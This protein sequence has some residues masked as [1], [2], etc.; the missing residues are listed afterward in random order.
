[1]RLR[2][3]DLYNKNQWII[4]RME[5]HPESCFLFVCLFYFFFLKYALFYFFSY[6]IIIILL[7]YNIVL[8]LPYIN[9]SL[10]RVYMC[11]QSWTRLSP[12]SPYHPS[13]SPQCPSPKHP[14]S[15][16]KHSLAIRFLHDSIHVSIPLM[17]S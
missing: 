8:V 9:M 2:N 5:W 4:S 3:Y 11:S 1:M 10:P 7:L 12:P 6:F 14:V 13:G 16:I 17:K 15:C